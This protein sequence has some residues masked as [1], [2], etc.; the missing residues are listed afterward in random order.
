MSLRTLLHTRLAKDQPDA[1]ATSATAGGEGD[2]NAAAEQA[3]AEVAENFSEGQ[4]C[5]GSSYVPSDL[6]RQWMA[7]RTEASWVDDHCAHLTT[8][9]VS[10]WLGKTQS[11]L[12]ALAA[13]FY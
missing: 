2:E 5:T 9:I 8:S 1:H 4:R 11:P 6:E 7:H 10:G 3:A 12:Y 13:C